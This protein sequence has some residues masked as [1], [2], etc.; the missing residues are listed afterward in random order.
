MMQYIHDEVLR[1]LYNLIAIGL[2]V[3]PESL[4]EIH[5]YKGGACGILRYMRYSPYTEEER[6]KLGMTLYGGGHTDSCAITLLF[7]QPVSALQIKDPQSGDWKWAKPQEG[8]LTVNAGDC[9]SILTGG[10]I[11]STIHRVS[12]DIQERGSFPQVSLPP[13]DQRDY[14]RLGVI[15]FSR[16]PP[17]M[18]LN[19]I[20]SPVL[21]KLGMD[22]NG[23]EQNGSVPTAGG[24]CVGE[25]LC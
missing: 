21:K 19:T 9:L 8:C 11:K 25:G 12:L 13:K 5:Q 1:K 4:N 18:H 3:P 20:N 16:P 7:R 14:E 15:Y 23:F 2:E 17:P 22:K 6:T 24:E 10:Y